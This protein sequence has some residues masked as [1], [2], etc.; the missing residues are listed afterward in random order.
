M[1][2]KITTALLACVT[3]IALSGCAVSPVITTESDTTSFESVE[4]DLLASESTTFQTETTTVTEAVK[5]MVLMVG[6]TEVPV[7]WEDNAS[8]DELKALAETGL[9]IGMSM[10]GDFEQVGSIGQ[11]ITSNDEQTTTSPGDIVLY[12]GN[13]IVIFYGTNT[14]EYTRLGKADLSEEEL[15]DLLSNGDVTIT[16]SLH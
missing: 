12:S 4:T 3:F 8:V 13:Q 5:S 9:S 11:S 6:G 16:L 7:I 10:Y 1:G 14:W 15:T 2:M